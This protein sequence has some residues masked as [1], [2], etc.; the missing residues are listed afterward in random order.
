[1]T[2]ASSIGGLQIDSYIRPDKLF[3]IERSVIELKL[4][5][6]ETEITEVVK[7]VIRQLFV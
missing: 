6:L 4:G 7:S 3:T 2:R 1:M 5:S